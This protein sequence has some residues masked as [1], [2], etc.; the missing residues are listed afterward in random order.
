M[1]RI[2]LDASMTL[3]SDLTKTPIWGRNQSQ[4]QIPELRVVGCAGF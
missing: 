2:V 4:G 3:S 1:S